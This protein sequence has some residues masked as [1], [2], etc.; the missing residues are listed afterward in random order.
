MESFFVMFTNGA[1]FQTVLLYRYLGDFILC[2]L[3]FFL[4]IFA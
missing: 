4:A 1:I 3:C 2:Y